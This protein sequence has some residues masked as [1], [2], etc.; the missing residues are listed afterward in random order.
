VPPSP[1]G[2]L[3]KSGEPVP[4]TANVRVSFGVLSISQPEEGAS[5]REYHGFTGFYGVFVESAE[6]GVGINVYK[7]YFAWTWIL[8][9]EV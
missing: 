9:I 5:Q 6:I 1:L 2:M 3:T 7:L 4:R 8:L